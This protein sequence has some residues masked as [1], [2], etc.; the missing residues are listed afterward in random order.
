[1]GVVTGL[2][3][4]LLL[5]LLMSLVPPI[6]RCK[7]TWVKPSDVPFSYAIT[8]GV[9]KQSGAVTEPEV[10]LKTQSWY[11]SFQVIQVFLVTTFASAATAVTTQII[12]NPSSVTSL[13]A[14][15]LPKAS[16]FYIAYI[17]VQGLG[18]S[19]DLLLN[20]MGWLK[21]TFLYRFL[22]RT[23][24]KMF[25]RHTTLDTLDWAEVYPQFGNL[26]V[27]GKTSL[28]SNGELQNLTNTHS[29]RVCLHCSPSAWICS[30]WSHAHLHSLQIQHFPCPRQR[31]RY[32][33]CIICFSNQ[34]I[35]DGRLSRRD[36]SHRPVRN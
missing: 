15:N 9:M 18:I 35:D 13:L 1:M 3:P 31:H 11:F 8:I 29:Y 6:C 24:R 20:S 21:A 32:A 2:L 14:E 5:S 30:N 36:L 34:T 22:D 19:S 33:G 25:K 16:N 17:I 27:I 26:G 12:Q 28:A 4:A 10:E 7:Y 23:P